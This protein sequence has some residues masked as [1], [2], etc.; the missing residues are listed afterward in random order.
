VD[1]R[2]PRRD[3]QD[4]SLIGLPSLGFP[5]FGLFFILRIKV[6][7]GLWG[8]VKKREITWGRE[9]YC[10]RMSGRDDKEYGCRR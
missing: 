1:G 10:G 5:L 6:N 9:G 7:C 4:S 3:Y 8:F 2:D